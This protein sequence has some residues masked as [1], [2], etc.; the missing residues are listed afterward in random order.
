MRKKESLFLLIKSLSQAEKR[1]LKVSAKHD[2]ANYLRLFEAIDGQREYDERELRQKFR[3]EKFIGQFHVAKIYLQDIILKMLRSY[4]SKS[5]VNIQLTGLLTDIE[6]LHDRELYDL[7]LVK[8]RKAKALAK[9]FEKFALLM[10]IYSWERRLLIAKRN[11]ASLPDLSRDER[12]AI[13]KLGELSQL[14]SQLNGVQS[15]LSM[16]RG[17]ASL[18]KLKEKVPASLRANILHRHLLFSSFLLNGK[19]VEAEDQLNLLIDLLE[20]NSEFVRDD[21]ASYATA[22]GNK[23][24]LLLRFKR[25]NDIAPLIAKIRAIP[26]AYSLRSDNKFTV[27]LWIRLFNLELEFYRD[28]KDFKNGLALMEEADLFIRHHQRVVP[29]DYWLMLYYQFAHFLFM[30]RSFS[31]ALS[32]INEIIGKNA[33]PVRE[34]IQVYARILNLIIHFEL[35]NI[36]VIRYAVDNC[37]RYFKKIKRSG[38]RENRVLKFFAKLSLEPKSEHQLLFRKLHASLFAEEHRDERTEFDDYFDLR[39]WVESNLKM[40]PV[41]NAV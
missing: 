15:S 7:C 4:S 18:T 2:N 10:E 37:R 38:D 21:P 17:P 13:D 32:C 35:G 33:G 3:G 9:K 6:I 12:D 40:N 25:L 29:V 19:V 27:R 20:K 1:Y 31:R 22:L 36:I 23:V 8:I 39:R 11:H 24:S 34:D 16:Q 14:W 41:T 30:N 5:S 28:K 26:I